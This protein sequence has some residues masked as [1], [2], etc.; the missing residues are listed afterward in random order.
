MTDTNVPVIEMRDI[1]KKFGEFY[2]SKNIN[3]QLK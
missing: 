3:L 2:A 1:S